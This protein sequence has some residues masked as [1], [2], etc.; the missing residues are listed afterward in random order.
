MRF[1]DQTIFEKEKGD[2]FR[3]CLASIFEFNIEKMPNFWELTQDSFEFWKLVNQW[4]SEFLGIKCIL[5]SINDETKFYI[6]DLLCIAIG[7]VE[8]SGDEHAV[9]WKNGMIHDPHPSRDG[10]YG[11]INNFVVFVPITKCDLIRIV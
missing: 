4:T 8:R 9:V 2:C 5:I 3:A 11:D 10:L 7:K 6:E 1:I